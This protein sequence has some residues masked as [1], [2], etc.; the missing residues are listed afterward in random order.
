LGKILKIISSS[1][2]RYDAQMDARDPLILSF[3][4]D[5]DEVNGEGISVRVFYEHKE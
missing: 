5:E 3:R 1:F 4:K 2:G